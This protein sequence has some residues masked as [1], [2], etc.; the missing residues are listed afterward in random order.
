MVHGIV[1]N[2]IVPYYGSGK[3]LRH[4]I[5]YTDLMPAIQSFGKQEQCDSESSKLDIA[6]EGTWKYY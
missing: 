3:K 5:G 4:T 1:I 6:L 2:R